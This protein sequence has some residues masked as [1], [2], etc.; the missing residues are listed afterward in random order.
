MKTR[1]GHR[2]AKNAATMRALLDAASE[3]FAEC[4]FE[5]ASMDQIAAR[6]GLTK[7]AL[8]YRFPSKQE[9]FLALLDDRCAA[10]VRRFDASLAEDPARMGD[11]ADVAARLADA[12]SG[13]WPRLFLEF[14]SHSSRDSRHRRELRTRMA[15]LRKAVA[16]GIDR[17]AREAEIELPV[18]ASVL[19]LAVIILASGWAVER[20]ADPRGISQELLAELLGFL[21]AG[22]AVRGSG[23][24]P[25]R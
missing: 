10:H 11:P 16:A 21:F 23:R 4:G 14:V 8:Y 19:A 13:S 22:A 2:A 25:A 3:T 7:G 20:L 6:A 15:R 12:L 1:V 18:E 17:G 5:A 24:D 9:L